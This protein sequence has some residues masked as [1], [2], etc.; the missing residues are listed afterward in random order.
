MKEIQIDK[1]TQTPIEIAL[2]IDENGMT[3]ASKLY[4]FL[5]LHS[6]HFSDWCRR[7][8]KNN[9]FAIEG[10]DY[11]VFTV[12]SENLKNQG[13]RPKTD[14]K[15]TADF[16]KKLSM[17]GNTPRHEEAR[18]YFIACEKGLEIATKKLATQDEKLINL[19]TELTRT[20]IAMQG[21]IS[22]LQEQTRTKIQKA[23]K[24]KSR[25]LKNAFY[26]LN[27][28]LDYLRE[29]EDILQPLLKP[30]EREIDLPWV[31]HLVIAQA[32]YDNKNLDF[33]E[34]KDR[35]EYENCCACEFALTFIEYYSITKEAFTDTLDE[36]L[37]C[38]GIDVIQQQEQ[39]IISALKGVC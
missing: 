2:Q 9:K 25:W 32:E 37:H 26:K 10:E 5:E 7:N 35:Y 16:A 6:A 38:I 21:D 8:I 18:A 34:Y 23:K 15:L 39:S 33:N 27:L 36:F 30:T 12:E 3:T 29:N 1:S 19:V 20:V 4:E 22:S 28:L 31:I 17:T 24:Y 14:Y 13:G 11:I